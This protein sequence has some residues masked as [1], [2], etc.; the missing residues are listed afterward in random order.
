MVYFDFK[1]FNTLG[2]M[3]KKEKR[4]K[5]KIKLVKNVTSNREK[6]IRDKR[7]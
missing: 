1:F 3:R 5:N 2:F 7:K 6:G 4:K